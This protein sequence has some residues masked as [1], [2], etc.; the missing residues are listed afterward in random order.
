MKNVFTARGLPQ[1]PYLS[2]RRKPWDDRREEILSSAESQLR[3]PIF[4]KP[5]R[6]GSSIGIRKVTNRDEL[7]AGLDEAFTYDRV[8]IVEQGLEGVRELECGVIGNASLRVTRPGETVHAG[9]AF[10][11]YEAKYL[12]PVELRCPAEVPDEIAR[13]CMAYAREAYLGIGARGMARVD[14]FYDEPNDRVLINEINTIPGL[15][16]TSMFPP[17]W[18]SEGLGFGDLVDRLLELALEAAQAEARYA[19]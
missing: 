3:Y 16:P 7:A 12:A 19:P 1:T 10:Y 4:T 13:M 11:D 17:V 14:F 2:V 18:G 15:T 9:P 6:Q 8:A 5:A